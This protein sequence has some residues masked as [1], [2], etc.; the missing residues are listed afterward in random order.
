MLAALHLGDGRVYLMQQSPVTLGRSIPG[1]TVADVAVGADNEPG[2][3]RRHAELRC[4]DVEAW[5]QRFEILCL[6][7]SIMVDGARRR[8]TDGPVALADGSE[9]AMGSAKLWLAL[10]TAVDASR[11]GSFASTAAGSSDSQRELT[12]AAVAAEM[13]GEHGWEDWVKVAP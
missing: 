4:V 7:H 5:P 10:G 6:G 2:L 12:V 3:S 11:A 8:P 1:R 13:A 9:I